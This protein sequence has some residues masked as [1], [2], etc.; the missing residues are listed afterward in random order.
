VRF[1]RRNPAS[2]PLVLTGSALQK[3]TVASSLGRE[4][5]TCDAE[6]GMVAKIKSAKAVTLY[7]SQY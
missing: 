3:A 7:A 6:R 4:L 1:E 5:P 2:R